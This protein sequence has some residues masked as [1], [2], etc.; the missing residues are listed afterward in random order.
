[1]TQPQHLEHMASLFRRVL[2]L[3]CET[4]VSMVSRDPKHSQAIVLHVCWHCAWLVTWVQR[5]VLR[6]GIF[7]CASG[8]KSEPFQQV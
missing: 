4:W 3:G 8:S 7:S 1:M 5:W 6:Q 2:G